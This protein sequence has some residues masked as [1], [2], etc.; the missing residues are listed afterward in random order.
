V[1]VTRADFEQIQPDR[2]SW[3]W[4]QALRLAD[5][6]VAPQF[7]EAATAEFPP[8]TVFIESWQGQRELA[9]QEA[10]PIQLV[11]TVYTLLLLFVS[12]AITA[13][14]TGARVSS[15]YREIGLMKAI[16]LTPTQVSLVFVCEALALGAAGVVLGFIPGALLAPRL[17]ATAAA[18]LLGS[19]TVN[20]NPIHMLV[21][22]TVILPLI[23]GSAFATARRASRASAQQAIRAGS[24]MPQ[25][26]SRLGRL[27]WRAAWVPIAVT[28]GLKDL[29]ARRTRSAWLMCAV[30]VTGAALVVTLC[31]QAA[32]GDRPPGEP[33]DVP[34]ELLTLIL[35]LDAVLALISLSALVALTIVSIRE[36]IRDLGVLSTVGLTP[37]QVMLSVTGAHVALAFVAS[38]VAVP[39]GIALFLVLYATASGD[40]ASGPTLAPWWWLLSVPLASTLVIAVGTSLPARL[41]ARI[42]ASDAV[43]YE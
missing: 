11:L 29:L 38:I 39:A 34:G 35:A 5:A 20:A 30:A 25:A 36:R 1:W 8:G 13:I 15:Q 23:A 26:G 40:G 37:T 6:D 7:V 27:V 4:Q 33:S 22:G 32:L 31:V 42:P 28:V 3:H 9:L 43:R 2:A 10:Q 12:M 21:A 16:G 18:S 24:A 19:P 14:L 41:A 17:T